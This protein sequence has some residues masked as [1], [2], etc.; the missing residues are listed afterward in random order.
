MKVERI[1]V[2]IIFAFIVIFTPVIPWLVEDGL[3]IKEDPLHMILIRGFTGLIMY[4]LGVYILSGIKPQ[5]KQQVNIGKRKIN[6]YGVLIGIVIVGVA[7]FTDVSTYLASALCPQDA[8][9]KIYIWTL[10]IHFIIIRFIVALMTFMGV[11]VIKHSIKRELPKV[12]E[13]DYF[14]LGEIDV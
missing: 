10:D 11:Y 2:A 14:T 4:M 13:E 12:A 6:M 3:M 9:L 8:A 7:W 1:V 5:K